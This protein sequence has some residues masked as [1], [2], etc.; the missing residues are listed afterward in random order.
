MLHLSLH[1]EKAHGSY[2]LVETKFMHHLGLEEQNDSSDSTILLCSRNRWNSSGSGNFTWS[3]AV[4]ALALL[5]IRTVYFQ[6]HA[7]GALVGVG[8]SAAATLDSALGKRPNWLLDM[9]GV[10]AD[11]S[12]RCR[13]LFWRENPERK[14]PGP[15]RV[16]LK[17]SRLPFEHIEICIGGNR[18]GQPN[19]IL[20]VLTSLAEG[21]GGSETEPARSRPAPAPYHKQSP[22]LR[23]QQSLESW[24]DFLKRIFR[25]EVVSMLRSTPL[26]SPGGSVESHL[27]VVQSPLF[28]KISGGRPLQL[29][30]PALQLSSG[31]RLG[32]LRPHQK[33]PSLWRS[34]TP[35][36]VALDV[37]SI[38]SILLFKLVERRHNFPVHL[39][40]GFIDTTEMVRYMLRGDFPVDVDGCVISVP[41]AASLISRRVAT[42]FVPLML[43]PRVSH[44]VVSRG[45]PGQTLSEGEYLFMR[46][47][48]GTSFFYFDYLQRSGRIGSNRIKKTHMD[49]DQVFA[50]LQNDE[51][52][53]RSVIF[54]PHYHFNQRFNQCRFLDEG[55]ITRQGI[56]HLLFIS[57]KTLERRQFVALLDI[58]LRDAW[59]TLQAGD[60]I[61]DQLIDAL[62]DDDDYMRTLHRCCGLQYLPVRPDTGIPLL[63]AGNQ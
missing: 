3:P 22:Q 55:D 24:R 36:T 54:F 11:G 37:T 4:R 31:A 25:D 62:I 39:D 10:A 13:E 6:D 50:R 56:E 33:L 43:F 59:I 34:D 44:R 49:P 35:F 14:R 21:F 20:P 9:F 30:E 12:G 8:G 53:V 18:I 26:F 48:P 61:L 2:E 23:T 42:S 47:I 7:R 19:A 63:P 1:F 57:A 17:Q 16:E 45:K 28:G 15:V 38:P 46:D 60:G 29:A 32:I 27:E 52:D 51:G 40:Y 58:A 5:L 41:A